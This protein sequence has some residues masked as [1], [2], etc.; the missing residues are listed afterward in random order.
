VRTANIDIQV[1]SADLRDP[2]A[3]AQAIAQAVGHFDRLDLG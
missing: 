2:A 3:P 1:I